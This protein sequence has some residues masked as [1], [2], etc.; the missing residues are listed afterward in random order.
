M[1]TTEVITE[2]TTEVTTVITREVTT[3]KTTEV[4][5]GVTA[6]ITTEIEMF[7]DKLTGLCAVLFSSL[8][9]FNQLF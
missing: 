8:V 5:T 3:G 4:I 9:L 1:I 2:V 6:V 7:Y